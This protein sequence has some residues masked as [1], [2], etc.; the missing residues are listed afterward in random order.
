MMVDKTGGSPYVNR[1]YVSWTDF[2]GTNDN[3]VVI[4]YSTNVGSTWSSSI[5]LSGSL[6]AG[7]QARV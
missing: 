1:L 7:S 4:R 3:D 6:N 5:N 2:G